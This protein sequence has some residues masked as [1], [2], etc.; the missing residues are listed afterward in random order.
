MNVDPSR[1]FLWESAF[2]IATVITIVAVAVGVIVSSGGTAAEIAT[3][4]FRW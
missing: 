3:H 2:N 1:K 4:L